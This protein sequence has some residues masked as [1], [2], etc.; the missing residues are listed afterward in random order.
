M[1]HSMNVF[2]FSRLIATICTIE[3]KIVYYVQQFV[4]K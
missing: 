1:F 3:W 2:F 4:F